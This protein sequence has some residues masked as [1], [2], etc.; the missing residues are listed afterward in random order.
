MHGLA[1][2][3]EYN[4]E[5]SV[6]LLQKMSAQYAMVLRDN[7]PEKI[8]AEELLPGDVILLEAGDIVPSDARLFQISALKTEEAALTGESQ[9]TVEKTIDLTAR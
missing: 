5:E 3:Q 2:L 4:A 7:N 1:I 9:S 8:N 6:R